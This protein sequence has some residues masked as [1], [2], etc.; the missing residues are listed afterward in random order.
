MTFDCRL[1]HR[2]CHWYLHLQ[3]Q[4]IPRPLPPKKQVE[5]SFPDLLRLAEK[6]VTRGR[7][8][9]LDLLDLFS[10]DALIFPF[11]MGIMFSRLFSSLFG[12][13]EARILVL[14]LDNAGKTTILFFTLVYV[15]DLIPSFR[16]ASD[17]GSSIHYSKCAFVCG[18]AAIGF[19]VET[20]QYNNIKFQ[21]MYF[22]D[23]PRNWF[24]AYV[25]SRNNKHPLC[26][27][28]S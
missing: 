5:F 9:I 14:G 10:I 19:N 18:N 23:V 28:M 24:C 13:K 7:L 20:V 22:L 21:G 17:G 27:G 3:R 6:G 8:E 25:A 11:E 1:P 16:S 4:R 15:F 2:L 26:G 12:S